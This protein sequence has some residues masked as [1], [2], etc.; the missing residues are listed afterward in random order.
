MSHY[1]T[2]NKEYNKW[3]C[4]GCSSIFRDQSHIQR[5]YNSKGNDCLA[6]IHSC[7]RIK[8]F[9]LKCGRFH[10]A[11]NQ[12][13]VHLVTANT[14]VAQQV[15]PTQ[16]ATA[17]PQYA[18][19]VL[20]SQREIALH[21]AL[22]YTH[23]FSSLPTNNTVKAD[24]VDAVL[25]QLIDKG[26]TTTDWIK[27]FFKYIAT[28]EY[29]IEELKRD[30]ES[31]SLNP[32]MVLAISDTPMAKLLDL[33][34]YLESHTKQI[35]DGIPA[36]WRAMLVEFKIPNDDN[37]ENEGGANM[38]TFRYRANSSP[39]LRECAY[40]ICYLKHHKC[41]ILDKYM[42]LLS[43]PGY[44]FDE[45]ATTGIISN[46]LYE[47]A[48]EQPSDGD[49][50]PWVCRFSLYRCFHLDRESGLPKLKSSAICGKI[51]A[52]VLYM[53]RQGILACASR[54]MQGGNSQRVPEMLRA[55]QSCQSIHFISPW[56][57]IC[58]GM[59][60]KQAQKETSHVMPNGDIV[61]NSAVFRNTIIRK[62]IP[63]VRNAICNIFGTIFRGDDWKL[64]LR[65][66]SIIKVSICILYMSI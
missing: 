25:A 57:S 9:Q 7:T 47:L 15:N 21:P 64:F 19:A 13:E 58:R 37:A 32:R 17:L 55:I 14:N 61:C 27:I 60:S 44:S 11:T 54:M 20:P 49:H 46:L 33:F 62:L 45:A 38:F 52:T 42:T 63:L 43:S 2:S 1:A 16:Q 28:N 65:G 41:A 18:T 51:F 59:T 23:Y 40:L 56:I 66:D 26:D 10:P 22:Q 30:L 5:H 6:S 24:I 4:S 53:L 36:N 39:Q 8:C 31:Q 35:A 48:A 50:I 12:P 3:Q 29:F 34:I